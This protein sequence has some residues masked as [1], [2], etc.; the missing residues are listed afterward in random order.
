MKYLWKV[1]QARI[2]FYGDGD[3]DGGG[4]GGT[5]DN[6]LNKDKNKEGDKDKDK[7]KDKNKDLED[8]KPTI[9]QKKLNTLLA[10]EKRKYKKTIDDQVS[11]LETLKKSK[12]LSDKEREDLTKRIEDLNNSLL[13]KEELAKKEKEK[14]TTEHKSALE[15]KTKESDFWK[16]MFHGEKITRTIQDEAIRAEAFNSNQI[17]NLL[18]PNTR[19]AEVLDKDG[20]I[21]P[22][23]Y[24]VKVT[25]S[26]QDK[27]G[28]PITLDLTVPEALKRMKD[29]TDEFGNLF[30]SGVVGGIG[31]NSGKSGKDI[32]PSKLTPEEYRKWRNTRLNRKEK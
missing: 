12:G 15:G 13:T 10:E 14:L 17:V 5:G 1:A 8:D 6:D 31:G 29:R 9:S 30:K 21:V 32:D 24:V 4:D 25:M 26:D 2:N 20:K 27:D 3:G 11:Q 22:G 28:N 19:L 18:K 16:N 23:E 7:D